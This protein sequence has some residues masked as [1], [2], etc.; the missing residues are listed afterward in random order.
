MLYGID[1]IREVKGV[2]SRKDRLELIKAIERTRKN[3][4]KRIAEKDRLKKKRI[5]YCPRCGKS[6]DNKAGRERW[7][8][9]DL[10]IRKRICRKCGGKS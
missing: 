3:V 6:R 8:G 9:F 4:R 10:N 1:G 7:W 5:K 2:K